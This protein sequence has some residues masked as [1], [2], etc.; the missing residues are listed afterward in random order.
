[1]ARSEGMA[2]APWN[3]LA[4]GKFR[5]DAEEQKRLETGEKGRVIFGGDWIRNDKEKAVSAALEKVA[6]EVGAK[7]ITSGM[8]VKR[9][10]LGTLIDFLKQLPSRTCSTKLRSCSLSLA[11]AKW[12]T[13]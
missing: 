3:V 2:L 13:S 6:Q 12:S 10:T 11:V 5:T 1:M 9:P 8:A 7:N 4:G